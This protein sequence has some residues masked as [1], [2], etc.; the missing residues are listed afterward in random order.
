MPAAGDMTTPAALMR[1][2]TAAFS[3]ADL[4]PL[5]EALNVVWKSATD[6]NAPFRFG[7]NHVGRAGVMEVLATI[8]ADFLFRRFTPIDIVEQ[9]DIAWGLFDAV[10]EH[11]PTARRRPNAEPIAF[12]CALRWKV[13][14]GK[15]V[16][17]QAFFDTGVIDR[18]I[19]AA[20]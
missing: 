4:R 17:H 5:F 1:R 9:G 7:G 20:D 11:V 12:E 19:R 8:S 2:I 18:A 16:E 14:D 15:L 10:I 3:K 6:A 13:V